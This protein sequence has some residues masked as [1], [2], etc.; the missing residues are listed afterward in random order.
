MNIGRILGRALPGAGFAF[1]AVVISLGAS[2]RLAAAD[3]VA[4][5]LRGTPLVLNATLWWGF[6]A[7]TIVRSRPVQ[8]GQR[9][10]GAA[11]FCLASGSAA[12][13]VPPPLGSRLSLAQL[14]MSSA[15]SLGAVT[16]ALTSLGRLGRCFGVLPDA[17]GLV[18][19]GPYRLVRHPLYLGEIGGVVGI[20]VA[21][22][23]ARNFVALVGVVT[24][25]IGRARLEERTLRKAFPGYAEYASRTPMLLPIRWPRRLSAADARSPA[26][27][28]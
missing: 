3:S 27:P 10:W 8:K 14:A 9:G 22:P 6:A 13:V 17:R 28:T 11:L 5:Q 25:Q 1:A 23:S 12:L 21:A 7:L 20:T 4:D 16:L 26:V 15:V 19:G 18:T 2:H 24:A